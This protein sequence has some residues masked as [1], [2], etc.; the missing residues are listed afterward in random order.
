MWSVTAQSQLDAVSKSLT[1]MR[2]LKGETAYESELFYY[3][4]PA[5]ISLACPVN[6]DVDKVEQLYWIC[7]NLL[8]TLS[9]LKFS[10]AHAAFVHFLRD[11]LNAFATEQQS[12]LALL[13]DENTHRVTAERLAEH[14]RRLERCM[15]NAWRDYGIA[16]EHVYGS[17]EQE[18]KSTSKHQS[19]APRSSLAPPT[20]QQRAHQRRLSLS[21]VDALRTA[22]F[23]T[24]PPTEEN[25]GDAEVIGGT[26]ERDGLLA[27][28]VIAPTSMSLHHTTNDVFVRSCFFFYVTRFAYAL[29]TIQLNQPNPNSAATPPPPSTT[30]PHPPPTP[31]NSHQD[32]YQAI[33]ASFFHHMR[34]P[35]H[36]SLCGFHPL[37]DVWALVLT[38][39]EFV[40][41]PRV[42]WVWF[43]ASVKIALIICTAAVIAVIPYTNTSNVLPNSVW[44]AFTAAVLTS[45]TEGALW[46]RSIHRVVGTLVGGL[47]GYLIIF[48]FPNGQWVGSIPLLTLWCIPMLYVQ[49]SAYSYIGSMAQLTPIVIVFGYTL[50]ANGSDLTPERYA[51]ARMEEIVIG[52][53]IALLISTVL[54]PVSSV[55]LLRSEMIVSIES[56]KAGIDRTISVYA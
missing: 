45:D 40:R 32:K 27:G 30:P 53:A 24:S 50:T 9:I 18:S 15:Q 20:I 46:Q 13:S 33:R 23:H 4:F 56:F 6:A 55:G 43:R 1:E 16:R 12:F 48:P 14:K 22:S 28:G 3:L 21:R 52:V 11:S 49:F 37:T 47:V 54:W 5:S 35:L 38:F 34:H 17:K 26:G 44:A 7:T 19:T 39:V 10:T 25:S 41:R 51:L 2:R 8:H 31:T 42:D 29:Q 36:W